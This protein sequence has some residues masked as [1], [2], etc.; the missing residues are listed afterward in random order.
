[1]ILDIEEIR[2]KY[3][4]GEIQLKYT[5][6]AIWPWRDTVEICLWRNRWKYIGNGSL[7]EKPVVEL[8]REILKAEYI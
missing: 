4:F 3:T 1:M 7:R 6:G 5:Y 2:W 8:I